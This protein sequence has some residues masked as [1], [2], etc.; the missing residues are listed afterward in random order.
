MV[1]KGYVNC[2]FRLKYVRNNLYCRLCVHICKAFFVYSLSYPQNLQ[3]LVELRNDQV[4]VSSRKVAEN[5]G[6]RHDRVLEAIRETLKGLPK[7]VETPE[8]FFQK[9]IRRMF[10]LPC[11]VAEKSATKFYQ[12]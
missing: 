1:I 4:V 12:G 6:R 10:I 5:F 2:R 11:L 7:N 8:M 9:P 3:C